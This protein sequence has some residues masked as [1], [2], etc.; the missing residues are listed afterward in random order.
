RVQNLTKA[1]ICQVQSNRHPGTTEVFQSIF[2]HLR[3]EPAGMDLATLAAGR[4][5]MEQTRMFSP[6]NRVPSLRGK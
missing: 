5:A 2:M 6:L 4:Y 3:A 1:E